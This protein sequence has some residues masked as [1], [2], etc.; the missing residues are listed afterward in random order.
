MKIDHPSRAE[1]A[2]VTRRQLL[3]LAPT[4]AVFVPVVG[5]LASGCSKSEPEVD[6]TDLSALQP[7]E[8][9]MRSSIGYQSHGPK[10]LT[11][12]KCVHW[13]P[14][15]TPECGKCRVMPGPVE[16]AGYCRLYAPKA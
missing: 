9:Q 14:G 16:A 11:C 12:D 10:D 2:L 6:C 3:R 8:I 1:R 15:A 13:V 5:A 4:A 7:A